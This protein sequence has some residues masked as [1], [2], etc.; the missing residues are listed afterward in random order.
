[1]CSHANSSVDSFGQITFGKC[2]KC[3]FKLVV[4]PILELVGQQYVVLMLYG[5]NV[6]IMCTVFFNLG[7]FLA[8]LGN[9]R[10]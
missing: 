9:S 10:Y 1:M 2:R 5:I 4:G 3:P 6:I 8:F 7:N